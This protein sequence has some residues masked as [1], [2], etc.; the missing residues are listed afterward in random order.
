MRGFVGPRRTNPASA[1]RAPLPS[2]T[3]TSIL[4]VVR[5]P[6]C[7]DSTARSRS[8]T[9]VGLPAIDAEHCAGDRPRL[10]ERVEVPARQLHDAQTETR[11]R[12]VALE[13]DREE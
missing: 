11:V 2:R 8:E 13:L 4:V 7:R 3:R 12:D 10:A 5:G 6:S 1:S 9:S